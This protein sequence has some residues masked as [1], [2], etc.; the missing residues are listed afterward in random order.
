MKTKIL[1]PL[2]LSLALAFVNVQASDMD[3][4]VRE[5]ARR[6]VDAGLHYLRV[7]QADDGSWSESVGVTALGLRA[8]LQS[9][10]G[11]AEKDGAFI[12]RPISFLLAHINDHQ[13]RGKLRKFNIRSKP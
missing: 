1:F 11:Y 4:E 9:H 8:F 5:K 13:F 10:R 2:A 3:P 7:N 12:T 6:A